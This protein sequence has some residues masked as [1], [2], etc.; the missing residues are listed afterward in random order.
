MCASACLRQWKSERECDTSSTPYHFTFEPKHMRCERKF[1]NISTFRFLIIVN[2]NCCWSCFRWEAMPPS[3]LN[4]LL[5]LVLSSLVNAQSAHTFLIKAYLHW[6][7]AI[8]NDIEHFHTLIQRQRT[9]L[10]FKFTG[11]IFLRIFFL[12][13]APFLWAGGRYT[14]QEYEIANKFIP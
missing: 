6:I 5:L 12:V 10:Y 13:L 14:S 3:S 1:M 8:K 4:S 2:I 9:H 7:R 11:F